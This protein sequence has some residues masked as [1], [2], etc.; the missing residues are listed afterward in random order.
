MRRLLPVAIEHDIACNDEA[1]LG[2]IGQRCG[3]E[4]KRNGE[5]RKAWFSHEDR[6]EISSIVLARGVALKSSGSAFGQQAP[7]DFPVKRKELRQIYKCS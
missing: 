2:K 1:G 5:M 7:F 6:R 3:H 4:K